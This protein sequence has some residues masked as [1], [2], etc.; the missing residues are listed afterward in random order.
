MASQSHQGSQATGGRRRRSRLRVRLQARLVTRTETRSIILTDL[1]LSGAQIMT[2]QPLR[3]GCEVVLEWGSYEAFGEVV[4]TGGNR[5]GVSF[6]DAI[7]P[8]VVVATR[9]LD[10]AAHLPQD[11]EIVRQMARHWVEGTPRP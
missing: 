4:W 3:L 11:K 5:C 6:F 7:S 1:S 9:D 10:D 2:D 8:A